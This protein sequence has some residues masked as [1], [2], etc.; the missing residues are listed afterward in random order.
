[1][2]SPSYDGESV[3][4]NRN[5]FLVDGKD[6]EI[7]NI[8][9]TTKQN[10]HDFCTKT[11]IGEDFYHHCLEKIDTQWFP[12]G[13]AID[14]RMLNQRIKNTIDK[15]K[16]EE[17]KRKAQQSRIKLQGTDGMRGKISGEPWDV[18][19]AVT[20]YR[21]NRILSPALI[22][23]TAYSF[24]VQLIKHGL[25]KE[26]ETAVIGEDGR[27]Q[28][29]K[30]IFMPALTRG[31][32]RAHIRV[33]NCGMISTPGVV[34]AGA[35]FNSRINAV[36][37]A[38]HNP[39]NQNGLKLLFD[40]FKLLDETISGEYALTATVLRNAHQWNE[41]YVI[42]DEFDIHDQAKELL[43][44]SILDNTTVQPG[45]LSG[46]HIVYDGANGAGSLTAPAVFSKLDINAD[47]VNV[48]PTG[49]NINL[50]GG[51]AE[52]EGTAFF[53]VTSSQQDGFLPIVRRMLEW[54]DKSDRPVVGIVNDG[55]ADRGY[56]LVYNIEDRKI[57]V[58]PG[59]EIAVWIARS[60]QRFDEV[61]PDSMVITSVESDIMAGR[62]ASETL[63]LLNETVCVGDKWLLYPVREGKAFAVGSEESGHVTFGLNVINQM[64]DRIK[65]YTGDGLLSV[66]RALSEMKRCNASID[67]MIHPF[68]PGYKAIRYAYF[69]DQS[70]FYRGS[71]IWRENYKEAMTMLIEGCPQQYTVREFEF[72]NCSDMLYFAVLDESGSTAGTLFVRNSGTE[73]KIGVAVRCTPELQPLFLNVMEHISDLHKRKMRDLTDSDYP[74][75][76]AIEDCVS[77]GSIS[78]EQLKHYINKY[79][80]KSLSPVDFEALLYGL[81]K[82]RT[83]RIQD[84]TVK[85]YLD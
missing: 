30:R 67:E 85:A 22:E 8:P 29:G 31:F 61:S 50:N 23:L 42:I 10:I 82:E 60:L 77:D 19:R 58:V 41:Q 37:T 34:I 66:L 68:I 78:L 64:G 79:T 25:I 38:S 44:K 72:P 80:D 33:F 20:E 48:E 6:L 16:T 32:N 51:V 55:D 46:Y 36:M 40:H 49:E 52:L 74:V 84:T 43:I 56:L 45:D 65:V 57:Y 9:G 73:K 26:G 14:V 63:G 83:I 28:L 59:D 76:R 75:I 13:A 12:Y 69:V 47:S 54:G 18:K 3:L 35:H 5:I 81:R 17:I 39:A 1:M 7:A 27:D 71:E 70:L 2:K 15:T 11:G 21:M 24:A 4:F 53:D 62:Y